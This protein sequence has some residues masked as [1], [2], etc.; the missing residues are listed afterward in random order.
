MEKKNTLEKLS[1]LSDFEIDMLFGS[2]RYYMGRQTITSATFP[3]GFIENRIYERIPKGNLYTIIRD[4]Q[5]HVRDYTHF[6][7]PGIDDI[8]WR[9]LMC[10]LIAYQNNS[11]IEV[12]LSDGTKE[13]IFK[14]QYKH[15]NNHSIRN[16]PLKSYLENPHREIYIESDSIISEQ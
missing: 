7:N 15:G 9:K 14:V 1:P 2:I 10:F 13:K 12:T 5:E 8:P 16:Y 11:F 3:A 4:L 6:G